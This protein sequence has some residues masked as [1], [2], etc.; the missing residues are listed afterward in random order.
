M[1]KPSR[2]TRPTIG[3]LSGL[4]T[5]AAKFGS[6]IDRPITSSD[7]FKQRPGDRRLDEERRNTN[8]DDQQR[9]RAHAVNHR[10]R[11]PHVDHILRAAIGQARRDCRSWP[12]ERQIKKTP[13]DDQ[14]QTS[15]RQAAVLGSATR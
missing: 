14:V 2:N 5:M 11:S 12:A 9:G 4:V 15:G 6:V 8:N 13:A 1:K 3:T 10:D 7:R